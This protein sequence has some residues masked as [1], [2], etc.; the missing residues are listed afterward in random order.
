MRLASQ[1]PWA[2]GTRLTASKAASY[3]PDILRYSA[4]LTLDASVP[5]DAAGQGPTVAVFQTFRGD[6]KRSQE[7][8]PRSPEGPLCEDF[9]DSE[10]E[11]YIR[12]E[13]EVAARRNFLR[14]RGVEPP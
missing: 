12:G 11:A 4:S 10:I 2:C 7:Q 13:D 9:S 3:V 5:A 1:I 6:L 8:Q 14:A